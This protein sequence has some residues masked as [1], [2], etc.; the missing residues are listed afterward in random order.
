MGCPK[1]YLVQ[2]RIGCIVQ[3]K[4]FKTREKAIEYVKYLVNLH[5]RV[6]GFEPVF[7]ENI[8]EKCILR[9]YVK[10]TSK[11][12]EYPVFLTVLELEVE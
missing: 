9:A 4:A 10:P 5:A 1:I 7:E 3:T 6:P 8:S 12:I 11:P 2:G